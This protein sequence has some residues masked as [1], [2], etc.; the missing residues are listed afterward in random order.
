MVVDFQG[1]LDSFFVQ[2]VHLHKDSITVYFWTL[3]SSCKD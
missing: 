1:T 3:E 2:D